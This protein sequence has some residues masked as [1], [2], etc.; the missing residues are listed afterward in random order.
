MCLLHSILYT[1]YHL[2]NF[3]LFLPSSSSRN[4]RD[5]SS[6]FQNNLKQV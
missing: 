6:P 5:Y 3:L 2:L 4:C 1:L